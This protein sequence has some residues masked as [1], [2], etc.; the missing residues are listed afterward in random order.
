VHQ[1]FVRTLLAGIVAAIA[2]GLF[3]MH[4]SNA[5]AG[6]A[7]TVVVN[8]TGNTDDTVCS[9]APNAGTGNCTLRE[10]INSVNGGAADVIKFRTATFSEATPGV[11]DLES[12]LGALPPISREVIIDAVGAGVIL[13]GDVDAD[14]STIGIGLEVDASHNTFSFSLLGG[15]DSHFVIQNVTDDGLYLYGFSGGSFSFGTV[16]VDAV[17][18][19]DVGDAA[20]EFYA[21]NMTNGS[22]T[23]SLLSGDY[24]GLYSYL[25]AAVGY[26]DPTNDVLTPNSIIVDGNII[27]ALYSYGVEMDWYGDLDSTYGSKI[28]AVVTNNL[29]K[30]NTDAIYIYSDDTGAGSDGGVYNVDVSHNS[31]ID[32][33]GGSIAV[34]VELYAD[35]GGTN[36]TTSTV[37]ISD[38]G[39][40][41]GGDDDGVYVDV[42]FDASGSNSSTINVNR[43]GD[44]TTNNS[45]DTGVEIYN[46][47]FGGSNNTAT[48]EVNDNGDI[49]SEYGVYIY[50]YAEDDGT[51]GVGDSNDASVTVSGNDSIRGTDSEGVYIYQEAGSSSGNADEST[52]DITV[53]NNGPI[54]GFYYS[55]VELY[56]YAYAGGG[57][58]DDNSATASVTGNGPIT[59]DPYDGESGVYVDN[60]AYGDDAGSGNT[61]TTDISQNGDITAGTSTY[62]AIYVYWNFAG[63]YGD[64]GDDNTANLNV[65]D[66]GNVFASYYEAMYLYNMAGNGSF[67][68]PGDGNNATTEVS[69]NGDIVSSDDNG[70]EF[71][72]YAGG[73]DYEADSNYATTNIHD[74]GYIRSGIDYEALY[75]ETEAGD[76]YMYADADHN[77]AEFDAVNNAEIRGNDEDGIDSDIWAGGGTVDSLDN[78]TTTNITGN[79]PIVGEDGDGINLDGGSNGWVCCDDGTHGAA[80]VDVNTI[81]ISNN[82][83][84]ILGEDDDGI[85]IED[86]CCSVNLVTIQDNAGTITGTDGN[87]IEYE[88]DGADSFPGCGCFVDIDGNGFPD[89]LENSVNALAISGNDISNSSENGIWI[90]SGA[91]DGNLVAEPLVPKSAIHDNTIEDND[92]NGIFLD[93]VQGINIGPANT[94]TENG[95]AANANVHAGI[96]IVNDLADCWAGLSCKTISPEYLPAGGNTITQNTIYDNHNA[97]EDT[98]GIDLNEDD[99][100]DRVGCLTKGDPI[101]P[102]SCL[103]APVILLVAANGKIGGTS[104]AGC[105]VEIFLA[106]G[107]PADQPRTVATIQHGEGVT[108]LASGTADAAGN[109]SVQLPCGQGAGDLTATGTDGTTKDT[110]E[111]AENRPF[112]GTP[113]CATATPTA[114][115]TPTATNTPVPTTPAPTPAKACG[116]VNDSGSVNSV[117]AQLVLQY[118]A[119]LVTT[120]ANL[121]SGDVNSSGG[122]NPVD[123]ALILQAEAG[124]I[125]L[126]SLNCP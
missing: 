67:D 7:V 1:L 121:P 125:T 91:F 89:A 32:S 68:G 97:F 57:I 112:L 126:G 113:E 123:A 119:A 21:T 29:F 54:R 46:Y 17:D 2:F 69:G 75:G 18:I 79:G 45:A 66:N 77:W 5:R 104:C 20:V 56:N 3:A 44:I 19:R 108:Y 124:L 83:G 8:S 73:G 59:S 76:Y 12:G 71:Y 90:S 87:G 102:N 95:G 111:F 80:N 53:S 116:D 70:I 81:N 13:D 120:L 58:G 82:T 37:N 42:D 101:D 11:I 6:A 41:T 26:P 98:L 115:D 33:S 110:S 23:N 47:V 22:V 39:D 30:G 88:V 105:T 61:A 50:S 118:S 49:V 40:I 27:N 16:V 86:I 31:D 122:V 25:A 48:T 107:D 35:D 74:N 52:A 62:A 92:E 4:V 43:N 64:A 78:H 85:D 100:N 94:I 106:D 24:Y 9:G 10:A 34:D 103:A 38:N 28:N 14:G 84:G 96:Q 51:T 114:S 109:F 93:T 60:E 63:S 117:D 72:T 36:H 15:G 99:G 65:Q 55:A